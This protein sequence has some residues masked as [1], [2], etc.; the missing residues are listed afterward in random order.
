[1]FNFS[2]VL[3]VGQVNRETKSDIEFSS[4]VI[5]LP[6]VFTCETTDTSVSK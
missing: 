6:C 5:K 3:L 2:I 4:A 1:M